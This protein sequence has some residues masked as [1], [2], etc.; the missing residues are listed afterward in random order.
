MA[1]YNNVYVRPDLTYKQR[2]EGQKLREELKR[3]QLRGETDLVIRRGQLIKIIK[4]QESI[5]DHTTE[6][7]EPFLTIQQ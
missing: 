2:Q 7:A 5:S 6:E 1:Q 3:R 4:Q